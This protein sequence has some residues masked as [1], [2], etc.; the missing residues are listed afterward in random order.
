MGS[1]DL[2]AAGRPERRHDER[3]LDLAQ[4][5][6]VEAGGRLRAPVRREIIGDVAFDR[7][8]EP[9]AA[10]GFGRQLRR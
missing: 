8:R 4:H 5:P 10:R 6:I 7:R 9:L 2:V 3:P 1:L